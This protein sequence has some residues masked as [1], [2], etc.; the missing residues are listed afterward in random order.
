MVI[1][2]TQQR[3]ILRIQIQNESSGRRKDLVVD[4]SASRNLYDD[5]YD[6]SSVKEAHVRKYSAPLVQDVKKGVRVIQCCIWDEHL[7]QPSHFFSVAQLK[8]TTTQQL[9]EMAPESDFVKLMLRCIPVE[10]EDMES[11]SHASEAAVSA[12]AQLHSDAASKAVALPSFHPVV[13]DNNVGGDRVSRCPF[14]GIAVDS[15]FLDSFRREM[16]A[17]QQTDEESD[18]GDEDDKDKDQTSVSGNDAGID[19]QSPA[20][21]DID[22]VSQ[23]SSLASQQTD[24]KLPAAPTLSSMDDSNH[25]L[26]SKR[27]RV[28]VTNTVSWRSG[29]LV[30]DSS[31]VTTLY[32]AIYEHPTLMDASVRRWNS[33]T[34][35]ATGSGMTHVQLLVVRTTGSSSRGPTEVVHT[36]NVQDLKSSS[37]NQFFE[38]LQEKSISTKEI[39]NVQLQYVPADKKPNTKGPSP[40]TNT[41]PQPPPSSYVLPEY[42]SGGRLPVISLVSETSSVSTAAHTMEFGSPSAPVEYIGGASTHRSRA[43]SASQ[44]ASGVTSLDYEMFNSVSLLTKPKN[45]LRIRVTNRSSQRFKDLVV[46]INDTNFV[47]DSVYNNPLTVQAH[48]RKWGQQNVSDVKSGR[49]EIQVVCCD[50]DTAKPWKIFSVE[51]LKT[52]TTRNLYEMVP[53]SCDLV[54][55]FL[56]CVQKKPVLQRIAMVTDTPMLRIRNGKPESTPT[57]RSCASESCLK[58]PARKRLN[59]MSFVPDASDSQSTSVYDESSGNME[60]ETEITMELKSFSD[61][62]VKSSIH[63]AVAPLLPHRSGQKM[64]IDEF[65]MRSRGNRRRNDVKSVSTDDLQ[66]NAFWDISPGTPHPSTLEALVRSPKKQA[67]PQES[68]EPAPATRAHRVWNNSSANI[69]PAEGS[70]TFGSGTSKDERLK[71]FLR[72]LNGKKASAFQS[73]EFDLTLNDEPPQEVGT[74]ASSLNATFPTITQG[75]TQDR[76]P[77]LG[78]VDLRALGEQ[79][80]QAIGVHTRAQGEQRPSPGSVGMTVSL[81]PTSAILAIDPSMNVSETGPPKMLPP[82]NPSD[83]QVSDR[84]NRFLRFSKY[85]QATANDGTRFL[86]A[87]RSTLSLKSGSPS[88]ASLPEES[89]FTSPVV[90]NSISS[91]SSKM[92]FPLARVDT[93]P[94]TE[95]EVITN[96]EGDPSTGIGLSPALLKEVFPYHVILS[97]DFRIVQV[98]HRLSALM[99]QDVLVGRNIS[100]VFMLTGPIPIFGKWDWNIVDK[101]KDKTVFLETVG[102]SDDTKVK[103]KGT[104][105]DMASSHRMVMLAL[106]PNVK[107]LSDLESMDLS[108]ADLPL[109][110]CQREAVLLG[111]HS[112]SEVKLT[113]HL[114]Q[115]HRDLI[116]SME[117]QIEDRTNELE[118]ANRDL[119]RANQQLA[120][121]SARQL[122][123]FACM[124]HEIRTPLNCIVGMSSLLLDDADEMDPM[125]ADSIRMINTSG[126]LLKAVVDDVLD[127]AKLESG[128][129]EVDIKPTNLQETLAS[130]VHSISQKVQEKN[131]RLRTHFSAQLPLELETD[132]R[133]LQQVLF[134]L[135]GNAGKFSK[136]D[137]VIDLSVTLMDEQHVTSPTGK[138]IRFSVKDYGKGIDK[139]DWKTI[140]EPFS[141]ASKETQNVYGG[142]GLGLS[143]TSKLVHRLGGVV[144]LDSQLGKYTEFTVD[145]PFAG[146]AVDVEYVRAKLSKTTLLL[147]MP[148]KKFDYSFSEYQILPEPEPFDSAV[149]EIYSLDVE[150]CTSIQQVEEVMKNR[151]ADDKNRHFA[152]MIDEKFFYMGIPDQLESIVDPSQFTLITVGPHYSIPLTKDWHLKSLLNFFP[153]ALLETIH[154][155]AE[156]QR[157][158]WYSE[159]TEMTPAEKSSALREAGAEIHKKNDDIPV[160]LRDLVQRSGG[161]MDHP[162]PKTAQPSSQGA[163]RISFEAPTTSLSL[164]KLMPGGLF[165]SLKSGGDSIAST[166]ESLFR[167]LRP[168]KDNDLSR[169]RSVGSINSGD[170]EGV[171]KARKPSQGRSLV[172]SHSQHTV[173]SPTPP[174]HASPRFGQKTVDVIFGSLVGMASADSRHDSLSSSQRSN[175]SASG[176]S[177]GTRSL[178]SASQAVPST[179]LHRSSA[180][181][182]ATPKNRDLRALYCED[183][184]VNQKVLSRHLSRTGVKEIV[185]V[186]NGKKGVDLCAKESFD[187]IFMDYEMPVMDGMEATKLIVER[188]PNAVVIFV[189]AHALE[190]FKSKAEAVG[191]SGFFSKPFKATD[192]EYVLDLVEKKKAAAD[193]GGNVTPNEVVEAPV[194]VPTSTAQPSTA[195]PSPLA[196]QQSPPP[197]PDVSPGVSPI[198]LRSPWVSKSPRKDLRAESPTNEKSQRRLKILIAEDN[199]VNQKVLSRVLNRAGI[200]DITVVDNGKKA[201]DLCRMVK[202]DAI[203]SDVEMPVMGGLEACKRIVAHDPNALVIFVSAHTQAEFELQ[204][205]SVG[206]WGFLPKPF[207]LAD[208]NA[209]LD[210]LEKVVAT[211]P[212]SLRGAGSPTDVP[213][214]STSRIEQALTNHRGK[215]ESPSTHR[216]ITSIASEGGPF[217]ISGHSRSTTTSSSQTSSTHSRRGIRR[218]S[219]NG[220]M[221]T[222]KVNNTGSQPPSILPQLNLKVLYAEDN[223]VNQKVLTRVLNR[224]GISDITVV[225]DGQ[226]AVD[227]CAVQSFDVIFMDVQMPVLDGIAACKVIVE[228]DPQAV[229]IFV[230]AHAL[231]EFKMQAQNIGAQ[232]FISKPFQLDDIKKV[233]SGLTYR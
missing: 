157:K 146:K 127:Y 78:R 230:T 59:H 199:L 94:V 224:A 190:E 154:S 168:E 99:D 217:V 135:L 126:D 231:D 44:A 232:N 161:E 74:K 18:D 103:V 27:V 51:E 30:V 56:E 196:P 165:A 116:D 184:L 194:S 215:S 21:L 8:Q 4:I 143:I 130:V 202:F 148:A 192:I 73:Q 229:V 186:D 19:S 185:I 90:P 124:S 39:V 84:I 9:Y 42:T 222:H 25:T 219:G 2:H 37:T 81:Q 228:R 54:N 92:V 226:K 15:G 201:V 212:P 114:D 23:S 29:D 31:D 177:N 129:F 53:E 14:S 89:R 233:L 156:T 104:V 122:E 171:R 108:M 181:A 227:I 191:A 204:A 28:R 50:D 128:S 207:R 180:K 172:Q 183:N 151:I 193:K 46:D 77:L 150:R 20:T 57:L 133:R 49:A 198:S 214:T 10:D 118:N 216:Q 36:Y 40:A 16:A 111:E 52:T 33:E 142:T 144:G 174:P 64:D 211:A 203:F 113:N 3:Q 58:R 26:Q 136:P 188:D 176:R 32:Q 208:V 125:H 170:P 47:Y 105:I 158:A 197:S 210:R 35:G 169:S 178:Q 123:H 66:S 155:Y 70:H 63:K 138:I 97:S 5:V 102:N 100:D 140:F 166:P 45:M 80:P 121:Q 131:I 6:H 205:N 83:Q 48:V 225:D 76:N 200:T 34:V 93:P 182:K 13:A 65:L 195:Q 101:M 120:I 187:I 141:Q 213:M 162:K 85:Q 1:N 61:P 24:Q 175:L 86:T 152:L 107:N 134:N 17:R 209:V 106:F 38:L 82:K 91:T 109:H 117:K 88:L 220:L 149:S 22:D 206:A 87:S 95:I 112:K 60:L 68:R 110:S 139:A 67:M 223:L 173:K 153:A 115:L 12:T 221:T 119:A 145:L 167:F 7:G 69:R 159:G 189:T 163:T 11:S 137:S 75:T 62:A 218:G 164:D 96:E 147:V 43:G 98:G 41:S 72:L 71:E 160:G 55:L 179:I 132:S 79:H